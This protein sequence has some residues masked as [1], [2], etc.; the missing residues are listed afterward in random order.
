MA[1]ITWGE[2]D[3]EIWVDGIDRYRYVPPTAQMESRGGH[4]LV[5]EG[6]PSMKRMNEADWCAIEEAIN[7]TLAA[8]EIDGVEPE[9]QDE[10]R[11]QLEKTLAKVREQV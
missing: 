10:V 8:E 3:N 11:A 7:V 6:R 1:L 5:D 9:R 2:N 4:L